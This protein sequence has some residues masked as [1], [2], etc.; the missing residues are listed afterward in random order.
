MD[1]SPE[2]R[3]LRQKIGL[4]ADSPERWAASQ[5]RLRQPEPLLQVRIF[6]EMR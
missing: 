5:L 4:L 2:L 1:R 6:E 3:T